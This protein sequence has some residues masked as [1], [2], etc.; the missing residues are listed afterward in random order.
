MRLCLII[1]IAALA[2]APAPSAEARTSTT[3]CLASQAAAMT[4]VRLHYTK[5]GGA[6]GMGHWFNLIMGQRY[7]MRLDDLAY[8]RFE[9]EQGGGSRWAHLCSAAFGD[10]AARMDRTLVVLYDGTNLICRFYR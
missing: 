3:I 8:L 9:A 6:I 2:L 10:A 4:R 5:I 1:L 7:C